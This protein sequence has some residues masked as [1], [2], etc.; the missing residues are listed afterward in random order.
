MC[1]CTVPFRTVPPVRVFRSESAIRSESAKRD[2]AARQL[3]ELYQLRRAVKSW[4]IA[5]KLKNVLLVDPLSVLGASNNIDKARDILKD[6]LHLKG[7]HM[8]TVADKIKEVVAGWVRGRKRAGEALAGAEAKR[9]K[10]EVSAAGKQLKNRK[11]AGKS[12]KTGNS[13]S[14]Q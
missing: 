10:L 4:L 8:A 6:G 2:D 7:C 9:A 1:P 12:G 3:K 14:G 5:K 13:K 11:K